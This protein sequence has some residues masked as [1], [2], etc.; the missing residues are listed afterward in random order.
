MFLTTVIHKPSYNF[1]FISNKRVL[2]SLLILLVIFIW[3]KTKKQK[4]SWRC[5]LYLH[6]FRALDISW[7]LKRM[8][9]CQSLWQHTKDWSFRFSYD[10]QRERYNIR[11]Y[12]LSDAQYAKICTHMCKYTSLEFMPQVNIWLICDNIIFGAS[13]IFQMT[14]NVLWRTNCSLA[15]VGKKIIDL[16]NQGQNKIVG[17]Y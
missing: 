3:W 12:W 13:G 2:V 7:H 6:H 8:Q 15:V 14:E 4:H 1:L 17:V 11:K 16:V 9:K 5:Q 10:T